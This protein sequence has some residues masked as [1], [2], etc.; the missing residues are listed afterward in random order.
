MDNV[1]SYN[2][3]NNKIKTP[4]NQSRS[5]SYFSAFSSSINDDR[6]FSALTP[7]EHVACVRSRAIDRVRECAKRRDAEHRVNE[8]HVAS[9]LVRPS[10]I[11]GGGCEGMCIQQIRETE[12]NTL[13]VT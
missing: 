1:G 11:W 9:S 2:R 12:W 5:S 8:I 4:T 13:F 6:S 7:N 3:P 10:T